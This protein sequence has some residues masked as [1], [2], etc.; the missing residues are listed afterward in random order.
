M[1]YTK[2]EIKAVEFDNVDIIQT[3]SPTPGANGTPILPN[4]RSAVKT[5]SLNEDNYWN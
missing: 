1:K 4:L 2:P 3:S 5:Q